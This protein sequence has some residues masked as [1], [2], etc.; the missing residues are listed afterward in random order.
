MSEQHWRSTND[1]MGN[2]ILLSDALAMTQGWAPSDPSMSSNLYI[3]I[4]GY[5]KLGLIPARAG[6]L[7]IQ[8]RRRGQL[9]REKTAYYENVPA[10]FWHPLFAFDDAGETEYQ[11]DVTFLAWDWAQNRFEKICCVPDGAEWVVEKT[12]A[13]AVMVDREVFQSALRI[14]PAFST[15]M[16]R[17]LPANKSLIAPAKKRG[18]PPGSGAI[19]DTEKLEK[20]NCLIKSGQVDNAWAAASQLASTIG[21]PEAYENERK[22]LHR[23]FNEKYA[24]TL[25][26]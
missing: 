11:K 18:R 17:T 15:N 2:W 8:N 7:N 14:F 1:W 21:S 20:M 4:L 13:L 26:K 22:R 10:N 3:H 16:L 23:K 6:S 9:I 12:V 25:E 5:L 24:E 19:D